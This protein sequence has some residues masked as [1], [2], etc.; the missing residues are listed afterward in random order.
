MINAELAVACHL[1]LGEGSIW[2]QETGRLYWVGTEDRRVMW[3]DPSSGGVSELDVDGMPGTLVPYRD[4]TVGV[5]TE[6][7]FELLDTETGK[8][9]LLVEVEADRP[10]RR[11]NDGKCDPYGRFL[12]GTTQSV[13]PKKPGP[14]YRLESE[15]DSLRA[16]KVLDDLLIPNGLVWPEPDRMWYID[17]PTRRIDLYEYPATGPVGPL[18]R[19]IDVSNLSGEPDG[20]TIDA[21]GNLWVAFWGGSAVRCLAPDGTVLETVILPV[22]QVASAAFGDGDLGTL[23][24]TTAARGMASPE[25]GDG[26]DLNG[27][28]FRCRG[29]A[30]G[31]PSVPWEGQIQVQTH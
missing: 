23:Y 16:V 8:L 24:V 17:T 6:R 11:M 18:I 22:P 2:D 28:V 19:S 20:M 12:A 1:Q 31:C 3:L 9:S 7:G 29:L 5:A 26:P 21:D 15:G 14:L 4:G 13:R 25:P 10:D 30:T 27:A